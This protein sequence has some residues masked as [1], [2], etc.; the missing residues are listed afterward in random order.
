MLWL[1]FAGVSRPDHFHQILGATRT[2]VANR[3]KRLTSHGI[4]Q[5]SSYSTKP[6]RFRYEVSAKG[7]GLLPALLVFHRWA[8]R[9]FGTA[10]APSPGVMHI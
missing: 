10:R 3:L 9:W 7:A 8:E 4:M 6:P 2:I 1:A 5:Q